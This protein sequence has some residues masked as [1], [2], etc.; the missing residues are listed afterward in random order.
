MT[1]SALALGDPITDL[2][3]ALEVNYFRASRETYFIPLAVKIPGS[4]IKLAEV[5]RKDETEI[6][7]VA[8]VRDPKGRLM[9]SVRDSIKVRLRGDKAERLATRNLTY[10]SGFTLP[11]GEYSLKLVCR[12]N[13]T[14]KLG[15]FETRF[16]VPDLAAANPY[17]RLSSVVWSNQREKLESAVGRVRGDR[18]ILRAHPLIQEGQKLIPSV[19][20]VFRRDQNLYVYAEAYDTGRQPATPAPVPSVLASLQFF[21]EGVKAFETEPTRVSKLAGTRTPI[22]LSVPLAA[23]QPGRYTVQLSVVD[24]LGRRFAFVRA[25]IVILER[26]SEATPAG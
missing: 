13:E 24:E 17:L 25:S 20:R 2:P 7:F 18:R 4:A 14:G 26:R 8:Q 16:A 6:E 9:A 12:E 5:G 23:L 11:A 1:S 19:T 21:R 10:D 15:T 22:E 3:L